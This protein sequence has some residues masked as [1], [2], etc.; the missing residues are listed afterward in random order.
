MSLLDALPHTA[1]AYR[2]SRAKGGSL[3]G[4]KDTYTA[5]WSPAK[6]CWQQSAGNSEI[7]EY[8]RR[9]MRITDKV[10]FV[11]NPG[12]TVQ[13]KLDVTNPVGTTIRYD[14]KSQSE[15]DASAGLGILWRVMVERTTTESPN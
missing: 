15:P 11:E 1:I 2:R 7:T 13:H 12:L 5:I 6:E 8:G 10:Y 14:V 4:G 9:G 3:G